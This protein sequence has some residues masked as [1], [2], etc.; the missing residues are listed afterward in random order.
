MKKIVL[1]VALLLSGNLAFAQLS[2]GNLLVTGA[3]SISSN[4][5]EITN[6]NRVSDG[7]TTTD[8]AFV[9]NVSY[10]LTNNFSLG[11]EIGFNRNSVTSDFTTDNGN[12]TVTLENVVSTFAFGP[13]VRYYV[14]LGNNFYFYGQGSIQAYGGTDDETETSVT[15][16]GNTTTTVINNSKTDLSGFSI[17]LKPGITYF[18]NNRFALDA[19]FGLLQF[20]TTGEKRT[21]YERRSNQVDFNLIP[22]SINFGLSYRFG[23][24]K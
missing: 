8:F 4:T 14:P 16:N 9:P 3:L 11:L 7:P 5:S 1:F 10:F 17:G 24:V 19:S 18:L 12:T 15:Q 2:K 21:N 6:N 22:N 20:A 23:E 13:F